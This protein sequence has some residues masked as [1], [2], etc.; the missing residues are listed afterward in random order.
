MAY[1]PSSQTS[2]LT[3]FINGTV[4]QSV[5]IDRTQQTFSYRFNNMGERTITFRT[6]S[7]TKTFNIM[8]TALDIDVHA[9]IDGLFLY[10]S[11]A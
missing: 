6:G 10:L 11:S 5:T 1:T 9:E 4:V 2:A 7:I 8:V 3:I